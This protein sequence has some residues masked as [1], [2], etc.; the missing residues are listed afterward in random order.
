MRLV[1]TC[2]HQLLS[3][4]AYVDKFT[5]VEFTAAQRCGG[6]VIDGVQSWLLDGKLHREHDRPALIS[7]SGAREWRRYG[8]LHRDHNR[9]A[10]IVGG[11]LEWYRDGRYHRDN[12][13]PA[14]INANDGDRVWYH[15]G[16]HYRDHGRPTY[17][18]SVGTHLWHCNLLPE[19]GHPIRIYRYGGWAWYCYGHQQRD[20]DRPAVVNRNSSRQWFQQGGRRP[21]QPGWVTPSG[22]PI[23]SILG[24]GDQP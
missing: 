11:L 13:R 21:D 8:H 10:Y 3:W 22:Q 15:H 23:R 2:Y 12:D 1:S 14:H 16:K 9:P 19:L 5:V 7:N 18:D 24:V 20:Q 6:A 4:V 17:V